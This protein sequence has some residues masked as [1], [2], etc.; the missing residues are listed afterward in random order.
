[1]IKISLYKNKLLEYRGLIS[2]F[3]YL[4]ALQIL[5]LI[6]PIITFPYLVRVLGVEKYGLIVYSQAIIGYFIVFIDF[7]FNI[8][9]I[10]QIS[11]ERENKAKISEIVSSVIIIKTVFALISL[12]LIILIVNV[13]PTFREY[14]LLYLA[15]FGVILD[16]AI[17]PKFYFQGIEK[18]KFISI[19]SILAKLVFVILIFIIIKGPDQFV[20]VPLFTSI[21]SLIGS[22][23]GLY[24]VVF[25]HKIKLKPV[26][27]NILLFHLKESVPFFTSRVSVLINS[28]ANILVIGSFLSFH[29]V[30]YYDIAEKI[31]S[32]LKIPFNIVNQVLFPNISKSK[33]ISLV[34]KTLKLLIIFYVIIYCA[35]FICGKEI[36]VLLGGA[37]LLPALSTYYVLSF[38]II[39]ELIVVFLGVNTLLVSGYKKEYNLSIIYGSFFYL[40]LVLVIYLFGIISL[41]HLALIS[42]LSS[43]FIMLYRI[44][45]CRKY[46][47]F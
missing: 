3:G 14:N 23:A 40:L 8:S 20:L 35:G 47:L 36:I 17:N 9:E 42:V 31:T 30:A 6:L 29:E 27:F 10:G 19:F 4:S 33:D 46:K 7:G 1:M 22:F 25:K 45:Y 5:T 44:Y 11:I 34:L 39:T 41:L 2:N 18:M 43:L 32:V 37:K 16:V 21:G 24:V 12:A 26:A 13:F 28:K 38:T 15:Y